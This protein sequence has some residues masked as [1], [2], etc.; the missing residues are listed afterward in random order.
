MYVD[1]RNLETLDSKWL[2]NIVNYEAVQSVEVTDYESFVEIWKF[3]K[4]VP[5]WWTA[6]AS[7]EPINVKHG[8]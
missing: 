7:N 3:A 5:R 2:S 4:A 1:F 8:F 6:I